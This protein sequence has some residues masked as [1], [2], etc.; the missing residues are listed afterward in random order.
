MPLIKV[1]RKLAMSSTEIIRIPILPLNIVNAHLIRSDSG[2]IL[3]DAGIPVPSATSRGSSPGAA[4][5]PG[6]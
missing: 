5:L 3:I 1:D 4:F 2:R 6:H